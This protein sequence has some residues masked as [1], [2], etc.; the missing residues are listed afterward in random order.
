MVWTHPV[1]SWPPLVAAASCDAPFPVPLIKEKRKVASRLVPEMFCAWEMV[2]V[3]QYWLV[4][5]FL[6]QP[7]VLTWG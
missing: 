2:E 6:A 3:K 5:E 7:A 4:V 1:Q